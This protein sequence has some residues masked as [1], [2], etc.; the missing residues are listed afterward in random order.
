MFRKLLSTS[1]DPILTVLRLVLGII[2]FAHGSGYFLGWFGGFGFHRTIGAFAHLGIPAP[3]A[4]V[5]MCAEFFGAI[6]LI[7]GFLARIAALGIMVNMVVAILH[8][9]I[10]NGFFMNWF[11]RQKGE[12]IEYHLL[13]IAVGLAILIRG[14]GAFSLDHLIGSRG[15]AQEPD[16]KI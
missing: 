3:L 2:F 9:N 1:N 16:K 13:V 10:R 6:G 4:F 12:G 14:A 5:A 15:N 8:V 7:V 11:G